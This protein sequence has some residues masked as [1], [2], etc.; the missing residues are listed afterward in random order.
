MGCLI[1]RGCMW[2]AAIIIS[3]I[4]F[5][6][7]TILAQID[8]AWTATYDGPDHREDNPNIMKI[9]AMGNV[10]ITGTSASDQSVDIATVKYSSSGELLWAQRFS[11]EDVTCEVRDMEIDEWGN[12]Y[13]AGIYHHWPDDNCMLIKYLPS[14]EGA[15]TSILDMGSYHTSWASG[16]AFDTDGNVY[17]VGGAVMPNETYDAL[18]IKYFPDGDTA[19]AKYY[20]Y[21]NGNGDYADGIV[22]DSA[23]YLY[24]AGTTYFAE[25]FNLLLI[26]KCD[27]DGNAIWAS[28][29]TDPVL[30]PVQFGG[31]ALGV[32]LDLNN[33][34]VVMGNLNSSTAHYYSVLAK[35]HPNGDTVWV[36]KYVNSNGHSVYPI[37]FDIDSNG[38]IYIGCNQYF[39]DSMDDY[40]TLKYLPNG[41]TA[42]IRQYDGPGNYAD[43]AHGLAVDNYGNVYVTGT[44]AKNSIGTIGWE[45]A[46]VKYST[47]GDLAWVAEYSNSNFDTTDSGE[48][49]ALDSSGDIIV[50]GHSYYSGSIN[51]HTIKY[52]QGTENTDNDGSIPSLFSLSSIYP[53]P[54]NAQT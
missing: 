37:D 10:Y 15:W 8:T 6:C 53:N 36:R 17:L 23:G 1:K 24:I 40:V 2:K 44:A 49:I 20:E 28:T 46:T 50:T 54:F 35:Y 14:G 3:V 29:Y 47:N 26:L 41:D 16:I 42:W 21:Q 33:D 7:P 27:L 30:L 39:V 12:I 22:Y 51:Y 11:E 4:L 48:D 25:C 5:Y 34:I 18:I 31:G 43:F 9:D 45:Y 52:T 13:I 38:N 19:W 32:K